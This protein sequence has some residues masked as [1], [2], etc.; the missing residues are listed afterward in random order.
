MANT[1][2]SKH[3][4]GRFCHWHRIV[5]FH[6]DFRSMVM[7]N[8]RIKAGSVQFGDNWRILILFF[9]RHLFHRHWSH[10]QIPCLRGRRLE[11]GGRL[12]ALRR[13][14]RKK[15]EGH[16]RCG[17]WRP[18]VA[19][20]GSR[21]RPAG[22]AAQKSCPAACVSANRGRLEARGV[23]CALAAARLWTR[24][25]ASMPQRPPISSPTTTRRQRR[26]GA[27]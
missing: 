8:P 15:G 7:L 4:D 16:H 17:R 27:R 12:L 11:W 10:G 26:W 1:C 21:W 18:R 23:A 13:G 24:D 14:D 19:P 20:A 25:W 5:I 22:R 2:I 9:L 3:R 6:A